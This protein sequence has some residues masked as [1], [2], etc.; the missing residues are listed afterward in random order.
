MSERFD[1][2]IKKIIIVFPALEKEK[3]D[4]IVQ[5]LKFGIVG[6]TNTLISYLTNIF[7]LYLLKDY[8]LS[9][10]YVIGNL[11]SFFISVL[12][13]FYWNNKYV[14]RNNKEKI[15]KKIFKTY[16]AYAFTG[17]IL[18]NVLSTLWINFLNISKYIAPLLNLIISVPVNYLI[19]KYWVYKDR[20]SNG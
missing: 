17:I 1:W 20:S 19:H 13:S 3:V 11:I 9:W 18:S 5:F 14:F 12:W 4:S 6:I 8:H 7:I 10:D 15:L 16:L 2:F